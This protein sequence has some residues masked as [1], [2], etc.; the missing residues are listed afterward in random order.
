M[1]VL[2]YLRLRT[3]YTTQCLSQKIV[4]GSVVAKFK[5]DVF[6]RNNVN[7]S[8]LKH[9]ETL[10]S[11]LAQNHFTYILKLFRKKWFLLM[12]VLLRYLLEAFT[13]LLFTVIQFHSVWETLWNRN[14]RHDTFPLPIIDGTPRS[15]EGLQLIKAIIVKINKH[16]KINLRVWKHVLFT[17]F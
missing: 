11:S 9:C 3:V 4:C 6:E 1:F 12:A 15:I 17:N 8:P 14:T 5:F 7:V 10:K 2:S 16:D 13:T